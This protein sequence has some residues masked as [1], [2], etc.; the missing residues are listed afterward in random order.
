MPKQLLS[1]LTDWVDSGIDAKSLALVSK[2]RFQH[3]FAALMV[4]SGLLYSP[5]FYSQGMPFTAGIALMTAVAAVIGI[6]LSRSGRYELGG[7]LISFM[8]LLTVS[9]GLTVNGGLARGHSVWLLVCP[10]VASLSA[11]PRAGAIVA[12]LTILISVIL[13]SAPALNINLTRRMS[14]EVDW[15]MVGVDHVMVPFLLAC[16]LWSQQSVWHEMVSRLTQQSESLENEVRV[17]ADSLRAADELAAARLNVIAT[18]S[19]EVRTPLQGLLGLVDLVRSADISD[20]HKH[21]LTVARTSGKLLHRVVDDVLSFLN[22]STSVLQV[23][24]V[25]TDIDELLEQEVA[26][27]KPEAEKAGLRLTYV[28]NNEAPGLVMIDAERLRQLLSNLVS[29][30]LKYTDVGRVAVSLTVQD[31]TFLVAVQDTGIGIAEEHLTK[32]FDPLFRV[33]DERLSGNGMGLAISTRIIAAMSGELTVDSRLGHGSSF[34]VQLPFHPATD[35]VRPLP[36]TPIFH[37]ETV[38]VAE[39]NPVNQLLLG[40][41]LTSL[42]LS[43]IFAC[44]GDLTVN[45]ALEHVPDII[46][47]D[48]QMPVCDGFEATR[49]LRSAGVTTPVVALTARNL[50]GDERLCLDAGM[51]RFLSKPVELPTLARVIQDALRGDGAAVS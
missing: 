30:A 35:E 48:C 19:H 24:E 40:H 2:S 21:L 47:M 32:I 42:N 33:D 46:L 26:L 5:V 27:W 17:T 43:P 51:N 23:H 41:M 14:A 38:L 4:L 31:A 3:I 12:L 18:L 8:L 10:V 22:Q 28:R 29:N 36:P 1:R 37:G 7:A 45:A 13:W 11:S 34:K 16:M 15:L 20:E 6:W 44:N 9:A 39:D 25:A 50:P 49:R